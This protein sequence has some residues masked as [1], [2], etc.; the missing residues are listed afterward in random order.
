MKDEDKTREQLIH[1]LA[2]LRKRDE[3]Y[4][5]LLESIEDGYYEVDLTGRFTLVND[6]TC[7]ILGHSRDQLVGMNFPQFAD[8]DSNL[9]GY[10]VFNDVFESDKPA[11]AFDWELIREDGAKRHVEVSVTLMKDPD[12]RKIGFRGILRDIT[13]RREA[14]D[15]RKRLEAQ[16]VQAQKMEALGT[17]A[18]G[19]AHHFNNLLM[20]I[21]GNASLLLLE[22]EPDHPHY[23]RL[24]T[25][26]KLVQDGA[27]LTSQLLGYAREGR[28]EVRSVSLNLLVQ[29]TSGT[30]ATARKDI[31]VHRN[32]AEDLTGLKADPGQLEQ[33]LLNMY[34]NA[35]DAMPEGGDIFLE[36]RNVT[37]ED[38]T[39]RPYKPKP[40]QYVL[41]TIRDTGIGMDSM[42]MYR[43]FEP[44][45]TTKD[46]GKG[47]GLGLASVYGVIKGHG[48]YVDVS[49][50]IQNGTTFYVYLPASLKSTEETRPSAERITEGKDT[51][52]LVDDEDMVI[53]V[54]EAMLERLGYHVLSA[55]SGKEAVEIYRKNRDRIHMVIL[56]MIMP[57][58]GG[59]E[60]YDRMKEI[61]P[62]IRVLLSSGYGIEGKATEILERGCDGFIQKPFNIA[63][64]SQKLKEILDRE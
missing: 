27:R 12:G 22:I 19:I 16:L 17:I 48:G 38:M 1:E 51:V 2:A 47:T 59:G 40:G 54:G 42:T 29:E 55:K 30:F 45:F 52:L 49:S 56:D 4:R 63:D 10:A 50:S 46:V 11:K 58:M 7:R 57:D 33:A 23:R 36:T 13:E 62:A 6:S 3:R 61:N 34:V 5:N 37:H 9:R 35:A 14:E 28:Y 8:R 15:Y 60:A 44:F 20:G 26:E 53:D 18:G 43:A 64:L 25:I 21:Q 31:R 39:G 41:L 32:L 24:K